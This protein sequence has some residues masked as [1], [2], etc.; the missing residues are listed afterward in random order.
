MARTPPLDVDAALRSGHFAEAGVALAGRTDPRS[1]IERARLGLL[2]GDFDEAA[3]VSTQGASA[4]DSD[5]SSRLLAGALRS[6]ALAA[7]GRPAQPLRAGD[8]SAGLRDASWIA[9]YAATAAYWGHE[10]DSARDWLGLFPP[11]AV[12]L[13]AR[14]LLLQGLLAAAAGQMKTQLKF[15]ESALDLLEAEAPKETYLIAFCAHIVALLLRELAQRGALARLER[16]EKRLDWSAGL[17]SMHFQVLRAI[18]WS[19]ALNSEFVPALTNI[20]R[21]ALL[22]DDPVSRLYAHLDRATVS[23]FASE[24]TGAQADFATAQMLV[25]AIDWKS[26]RTEGIATLPLAAATAAELQQTRDARALLALAEATQG[27]MAPYWALAHG[28]RMRGFIAE[29]KALTDAGHNHKAAID[30]ARRAFAIFDDIGYQWRA[31]RMA[32]LLLTLTG[33]KT[34]RAGAER[35]LAGYSRS[36]F[37]SALVEQTRSGLTVRQQEVLRLTLEGKSGAEIAEALEISI[38]TVYNHQAEIKRVKGA[39]TVTALV[40]SDGGV[41]RKRERRAS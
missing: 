33:E 6:C 34:W 10:Y 12:P 39:R 22:L 7:L 36:P 41:K 4:G 15:A 24:R 21:A 19:Y 27:Q 31:G 1:L 29:S 18:G 26:V 37:A 2:S 17:E 3:R 8:V 32:T 35:A 38:Y 16:L 23:I 5:R 25:K 14:Y 20:A 13:R 11:K 40:A 28:P 9:Y 30:S